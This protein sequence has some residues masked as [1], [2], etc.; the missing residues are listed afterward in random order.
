MADTI[1]SS[2]ELVVELY[3]EQDGTKYSRNLRIP[4]PI[5]KAQLSRSGIATALEP[6]IGYVD[7]TDTATA[8]LVPYFYDDT[9]PEIGL[10]QIGNIEYIETTKTTY[11]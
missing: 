6:A 2:R 9:R 8:N 7:S 4:N 5:N 10:T 11:E 3:A 1:T